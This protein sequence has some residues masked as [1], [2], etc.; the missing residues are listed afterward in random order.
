MEKVHQEDPLWLHDVGLVRYKLNTLPLL[1]R[2][3]VLQEP[4]LSPRPFLFGKNGIFWERQGRF[5]NK[6]Y[7]E[8]IPTQIGPNLPEDLHDKSSCAG[9]LEHLQT[10]DK[11]RI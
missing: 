11:P 4:L 1:Q 6:G 9:S 10:K 2:G 8:K 7:P 3:W 5:A